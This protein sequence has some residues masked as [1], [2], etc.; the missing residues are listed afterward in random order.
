MIKKLLLTTL[1]SISVV[2]MDIVV[3]KTVK[4]LDV[5]VDVKV[6]KIST[7]K[8]DDVKEVVVDS[9]T[10][11]M[12]QDNSDAQSVQKNWQ[13]AKEYCHNLNHAGYSDWQLPTISEL[14]TLIDTTK[15]DLAIKKGFNHVVSSYYWS[16]SPDI[17]GSKYAW[18][19]DFSNGGSY[20]DDKT[21]E[22]YVRC[23]RAGQ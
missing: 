13:D 16:S 11:L 18:Y 7:L 21:D 5:K 20:D 9:A 4:K 22:Y 15:Y 17:S 6:E 1:L 10:G 2:G 19:V 23:A 3:D 12:W 14:E 8:R